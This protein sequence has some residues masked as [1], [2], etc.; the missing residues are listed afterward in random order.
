MR[1]HPLNLLIALMAAGLLTFG[2]A[3]ADANTIKGTLAVGSFL[4]LGSTLGAALGLECLD[5]R[6][7]VNLRVLSGIFFG[8][9]LL[10][11]LVF[12]F[13]GFSQTSYVIVNGIVFLGFVLAGSSLVGARQA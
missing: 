8:I 13:G 4:V 7:G 10:L 5:R 11:Q 2:L 3:S 9:S 6:V 1:V 12:C